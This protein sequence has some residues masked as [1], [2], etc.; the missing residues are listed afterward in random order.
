VGQ[1]GLIDI[2]GVRLAF[3][4]WCLKQSTPSFEHPRVKV[5]V[6]GTERWIESDR[7]PLAEA[8]PKPLYLHSGGSANSSSGD[9]RLRWE[10]PPAKAAPDRFRHDPRNPVPSRDPSGNHADIHARQDVL[11]YTSD[12]LTGPVEILGRVFVKLWAST[13][14]KDTDFTAKLLDVH[15]D[16]KSVLI[17]TQNVGVRRGRY[18]KG[19][20]REVLLKPGAIE[21]YSIELF[22]IGHAFLPGHRIRVEIASSAS[23]Y[24]SPNHGTG[25]PIATD[26]AFVVANQTVYHDSARPS[27]ILLP[28]LSGGKP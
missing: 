2:Q 26:T 8:T 6:T 13:D 10:A 11:V 7:Y 16:G 9:G 12:S 4:D 15:P 25:N 18:L 23:P 3:F 1:P 14:A 19:Y 27:R 20:D 28:V 24:I 21:E 5:Y 22:D 17:G